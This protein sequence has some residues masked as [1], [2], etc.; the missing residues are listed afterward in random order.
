MDGPNVG[1]DSVYG[2]VPDMLLHDREDASSFKGYD[3]TN[4]EIDRD[5]ISYL[6]QL[7]QDVK[8]DP[9]RLIRLLIQMAKSD[10]EY[11]WE[12]NDPRCIVDLG[13]LVEVVKKYCLGNDGTSHIKYSPELALVLTKWR[14]NLAGYWDGFSDLPEYAI[15]ER[16]EPN[17]LMKLCT[18]VIHGLLAPRVARLGLQTTRSIACARPVVA[19]DAA[20]EWLRMYL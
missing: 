12:W 9:T 14:D 20:M 15:R 19:T 16:I 6:L 17:E 8:Q 13:N 18:E 11:L 10:L 7:T 1:F 5:T 3:A 2:R 4:V